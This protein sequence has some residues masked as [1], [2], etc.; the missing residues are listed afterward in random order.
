VT[1]QSDHPSV[2]AVSGNGDISAVAPGAASITAASEGK[3]A[4]ASLTVSAPAPVPVASVSVSPA[5]F[6]LQIGATVQ[7]SATMRDASNAVLTGR[8][9][10]WSSANAGIASVSSSGLVSAVSAGTTQITAL[11]EGQSSSAT[12]TV[13]APAPAPVATVSVSPASSSPVVGSTVQLS[14]TLRDANGTLLTGRVVTWSSANPSIA[15]VN[16]AS[17][18]VTALAAGPATT[19]TAMSETKT[20]TATVSVQAPPPPPPPGSSN[21]PSGMTPINERS[22]DALNE[23]PSW[24]MAGFSIAQDATAPKSPS[25]VLRATYQAGFAG[26]SSPGVGE[27]SF[28]DQRVLYISYWAK[29]SSNFW[30]HVTGV[31]KQIY[32]WANGNPIFYFEGLGVGTQALTPQ[33][34]IQGTPRDQVLG[35]N[36]VPGAVIPRGQW[37]HIEIVLTGNSAG[38]VDG[39]VDWWVDGVHVG[40]VN[41]GIQWTTAATTWNIFSLRAIWGGIGDVVPATMYLD[42]DHLYLSGKN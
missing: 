24:Y 23:D 37:Y 40:S 20:G 1:W 12:I 41:S 39:A 29:L 4:S 9:V 11:S 32:V 6:T 42:T 15:S 2:A 16:S 34:V 38:A 7:L 36:L 31:N 27:K 28:S 14:A 19:I 17:G 26:G 22:F 3:T 18:L 13:S 30:G 35:P 25:N 10:S 5:T 33:A 21:E 8:V